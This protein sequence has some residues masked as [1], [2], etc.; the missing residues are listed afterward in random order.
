MIK[1]TD[2]SKWNDW[3]WQLQ[4]RITTLEELSKYIELTKEEIEFFD[5]VAEEYP[6]AVTPYYLSLIKDPKDQKRSHKASN[7]PKPS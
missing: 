3:R 6:F 2:K 7:S 1:T 4:N 5:A